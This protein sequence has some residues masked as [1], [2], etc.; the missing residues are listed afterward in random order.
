[1]NIKKYIIMLLSVILIFAVSCSGNE[2]AD[3]VSLSLI[4]I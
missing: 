4:H 2:D 1:M 3:T